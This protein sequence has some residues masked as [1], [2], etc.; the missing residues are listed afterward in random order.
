LEILE[1]RSRGSYKLPSKVGLDPD[2]FFPSSDLFVITTSKRRD[3]GQNPPAA[4]FSLKQEVRAKHLGVT[5]PLSTVEASPEDLKQRT[6]ELVQVLRSHDLYEEEAAMLHREQVLATLNQMAQDWVYEESIAAGWDET[7][8]S[9]CRAMLRTFGSFR[10]GVHNRGADIDTLL[11]APGHTSKETFF[12]NFCA[13]LEADPKATDLQ[14]VPDAYVPIIKMMYDGVDIDLIYAKQ[15]RDSIPADFNLFDN[16]VLNS[17]GEE[18]VRSLN[19]CRVTD[20]ILSLVPNV[21]HFR[22]ALRFIKLWAKKRA[23]YS[24][25]FG[26][27][28]GV[29]WA[30]LVARVCQ[31]FPNAA[32]N[33]LLN[34]FFLFYDT[35]KW[36][37]PIHLVH[38]ESGEMQ[39][40]DPA[41]NRR[42]RFDLMPIITPAY[43]SINSTHNISKATM[44]VIKHELKRGREMFETVPLNGQ[45]IWH[46]LLEP[47]E[48]LFQYKRYLRVCAS[49]RSSHDQG[50]WV[51]WVKARV[52]RFITKL[53]ETLPE[54]S[55]V[56][57]FCS[58]F[59]QTR[60]AT[61][62]DEQRLDQ[63]RTELAEEADA[64]KAEA[65]ELGEEV[66]EEKE[67][68]EVP[69]EEQ[70]K[71]F[72]EHLWIGLAFPKTES[73]TQAIDLVEAKKGFI[74][75]INDY[76]TRKAG[77]TI[78]VDLVSRKN[79]PEFVFP[80]DEPKRP[81]NHFS[82]SKKRKAAATVN[83]AAAAKTKKAKK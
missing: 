74:T 2:F 71:V 36:P 35:W 50:L 75:M 62:L 19:G 32:P 14:P 83:A 56:H 39:I 24:N 51:G 20:S 10:L 8:A 48:F 22:T 79:L 72:E 40:W 68:K 3:C 69:V 38:P 55:D 5:D 52:R 73:T 58:T 17:G 47:S 16:S 77:M 9:E 13:K 1:I 15:E 82:L 6:P 63:Q 30:M 4:M 76:N 42:D 53:V 64:A 23:V 12:A 31:L 43:P 11:I 26:Y 27:L 67:E 28:G 21:P 66:E 49:S 44:R 46:K 80:E 18:S 41:V 7:R 34:R 57:L 45:Q 29:S 65:L 61:D 60:D 25:A 81:K 78:A 54:G 70:G 59:D 33:V 37:N